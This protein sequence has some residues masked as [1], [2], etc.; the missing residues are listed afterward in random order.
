LRRSGR[1][2]DAAAVLE[3]GLTDAP[4]VPSLMWIKAGELE[5]SGDIDGAIAIYEDLYEQD[6]SNLIVANNLASLIT[7]HRASEEELERAF[8][9][10]RR[11]RNSDLAPFQDTYGWIEYRR[12]N[13]NEAIDH[14]EK[15]AIGLPNDPLV[16]FHYGMALV[17][18]DQKE[19]AKTQLER[20][21]AIAGDS[22]LPQFDI[23]RETLD[24]LAVE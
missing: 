11:L 20:A 21:L 16:Q 8:S 15:A 17:A 6:S 14:L 3:K 19:S 22:D 1:D 9:I 7:T 13:F 2:E 10:A 24:K 4:G 23:A 12:G 18:V 5:K